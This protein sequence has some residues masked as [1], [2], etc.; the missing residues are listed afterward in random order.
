MVRR[1]PRLTAAEFVAAR[2]CRD[3]VQH[4]IDQMLAH[5]PG[6]M[7]C[8]YRTLTAAMTNH[9]K[10]RNVLAAAV[11]G[12]AELIVTENIRDFPLSATKSYD[13]EV[14]DQDV[15]LL[16]QLDLESGCVYRAL[17]WQ[18]S[19]YRRAPRTI[20][21]LLIELGRDGNGCPR[22]AKQ[23]HMQRARDRASKT[24]EIVGEVNSVQCSW[25][26][27]VRCS[28]LPASPMT[29]PPSLKTL[30]VIASARCPAHA[31]RTG[32]QRHDATGACRF[33]SAGAIMA[34]QTSWLPRCC[35]SKP[36]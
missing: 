6:S 9:P 18:V 15:F 3:R 23:C 29:R 14:V 34:S 22:F 33:L 35:A 27:A 17:D 31:T 7:V 26:S 4:R 24:W 30:P 13:I 10:D 36:L 1:H 32:A 16:D 20:D 25:V 11:R 21:D 12:N 5:F 28:R 8:D 2:C 19:R